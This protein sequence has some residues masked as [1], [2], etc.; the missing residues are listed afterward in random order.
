MRGKTAFSIW[1]RMT[2][3][4]NIYAPL[5]ERLYSQSGS[6]HAVKK[7]AESTGERSPEAPVIRFSIR[8]QVGFVIMLLI[9]FALWVF[10]AVLMSS[11]VL[12]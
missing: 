6:G 10:L 3:G 8:E 11:V 1:A 4:L 12:R 2:P 9:A 5:I 7:E